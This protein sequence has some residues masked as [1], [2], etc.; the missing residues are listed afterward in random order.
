MTTANAGLGLGASETEGGT[1]PHAS[2]SNLA[3]HFDSLQQQYEAAK[4]GMWLF[5]GTEVL[6][7][8]GLFCL[9]AVLRG[10]DPELFAWGSQH[11][12][13]GL[14]AT[15]TVVLII[16]SVTMALAVTFAQMGR[17]MPVILTLSATFLCGVIFMAIKSVEYEH[18]W[19]DNLVWGLG[20]YEVPE[21]VDP[22]ATGGGATLAPGDVAHGIELWNAT[23]RACHGVAG[24]GV[25]GQ[26]RDIR[27]AEYIQVRDDLEL[28]AFIKEGRLASD[29]L[30]STGI[31]MPPKGGN[32]MLKDQDLIDIIAYIRSFQIPIEQET[33]E[34]EET[35]DEGGADVPDEAVEAAPAP[36]QVPAPPAPVDALWPPKSVLPNAAEGPGGISLDA[37]E[38]H[39]GA[40]QAAHAPEPRPHHTIDPTRPDNAHLFFGLYFLMTGLHGLHVL[41][42][43][44][45][46]GWL[47]FRTVFD[48]FGRSYYTPIDLGGLYWHIVDLIWIFLFPLYYLI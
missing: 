46:I 20:F 38:A 8:G 14:G 18:K 26:G 15:N 43:M 24:E 47:I 33:P 42:G 21:D 13:V 45:I 16:S 4:L 27:S 3:H 17:R 32:P 44:G 23:C 19:H 34:G 35:P 7:F 37:I 29:P 11:L 12:D 6:L 5:L 39:E 9:Y 22:A 31:Q 48:H 30:N 41:I 36:A 40:P 1:D 25:I 2:G 28:V 10:D